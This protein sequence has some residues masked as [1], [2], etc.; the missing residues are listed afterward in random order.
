MILVTP[1]FFKYM[2]L[3]DV[4]AMA[5]FPFVLLSEEKL[6][7][8][9]FLMQH[10][11]IHLQQQKEL[12]I[13]PFYAL[14]V[15]EYLVKLIKTGSRYK[16]YRRISFEREAFCHES[17]INYLKNRPKFASFKYLWNHEAQS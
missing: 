4:R 1:K 11:K 10:E 3:G 13:L 7:Y 14:Y 17:E 12:L 8:D 2:T 16:A 5:V 6:Q 9:L 15:G